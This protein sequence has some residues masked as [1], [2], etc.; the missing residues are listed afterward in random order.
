MKVNL[1]SHPGKI[2]RLP[3][4]I[5]CQLGCGIHEGIPGVRLVGWL[6]SLP[7]VQAI[8]ESNF[9]GR[10]INEQNLSK[11]KVRGYPDWLQEC[12]FAQATINALAKHTQSKDIHPPSHDHTPG[13]F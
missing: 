9:G 4:E 8:L 12:A 7:E 13:Q 1:R 11:W 6:N 3:Y 5:R 10:P 2:G